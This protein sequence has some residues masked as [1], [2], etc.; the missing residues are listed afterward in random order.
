[1][2]NKSYEAVGQA[3]LPS[4][5]VL[6]DVHKSY[7]AST[8]ATPV[9]RGISLDIGAEL[10]SVISGPSGSGKTTLL[11][12]IGCIDRVDRGEL[13]VLDTEVSLLSDNQLSDFRRQHIGF[14]F[15][16]FNLLPVL[17]AFENVEYPL[18]LAGVP[19]NKRRSLV[20]AALEQVG[21]ADQ[22]NKIPGLMSGGQ[23]QRVAIARALV[24]KPALVLA[25]EP[26]ANLDSENGASIIA[27][28][29]TLQSSHRIAFVVCSHDPQVHAAADRLY[30]IRDGVLLPEPPASLLPL[31]EIE[32]HRN[33]RSSSGQLEQLA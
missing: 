1:M 18:M 13:T 30:A 4:A 21:I 2:F 22:M 29:K 9:L 6:R 17:S 11:N 31:G 16:N 19:I 20:E 14:I 25:D 15:Q 5:V 28:M 3:K 33:G 26:T 23:R 10:L 7:L 32:L 24:K 8:V 12:L 27:L